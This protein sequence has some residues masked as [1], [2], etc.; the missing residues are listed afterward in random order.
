MY[1]EQQGNNQSSEESDDDQ[2]EGARGPPV[3]HGSPIHQPQVH[4]G[5]PHRQNQA[6]WDHGQYLCNLDP[7][8]IVEGRRGRADRI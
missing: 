5:R 6:L 2:Q 1:L 4:A 3:A 8:N 7:A